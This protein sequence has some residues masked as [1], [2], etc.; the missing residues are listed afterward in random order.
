MARPPM[1]DA[2]PER[3]TGS[4]GRAARLHGAG[5]GAP[6]NLVPQSLVLSQSP[7]T[8]QK[9]TTQAGSRR[10][11]TTAGHSE[12]VRRSNAARDPYDLS[13]LEDDVQGSHRSPRKRKY[14]PGSLERNK[15]EVKKAN[16]SPYIPARSVAPVKPSGVP[17]SEPARI[18]GAALLNVG[19]IFAKCPQQPCRVSLLTAD[20]PTHRVRPKS[21]P[22]SALSANAGG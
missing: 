16:K 6:N 22:I 7:T 9:G 3:V 8:R 5:R 17:A 18:G 2:S 15:S 1:T 10:Q 19:S 12:D 13:E 20:S 14:P 21:R 11:Q 4:Y